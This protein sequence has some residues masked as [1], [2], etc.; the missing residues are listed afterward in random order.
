MYALFIQHTPKKAKRSE[1]SPTPELFDAQASDA[2]DQH[3]SFFG[4][5]RS[6]SELSLFSSQKSRDLVAR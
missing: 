4:S 1:K 3:S 5:E 2:G 6:D